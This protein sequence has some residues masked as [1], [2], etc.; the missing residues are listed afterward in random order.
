MNGIR[1]VDLT[2]VLAGPWATQQLADQGAEVIKIEPPTGDET[3][4]FGPLVQGHST[5]F[6]SANRNKR[7]ICL[8]LKTEAGRRVLADLV[9][10]ADV[11]IENFRPDVASR[12]GLDWP[13]LHRAHP[14]LVYVAIH[15]FG[16]TADPAWRHRPGYDLV[17][18]AMGGAAAATGFPGGPPV[19]N[20]TSVADLL[21]GL[22]AVQAVLLGLLERERSGQGQKIVVNMLQGQAAALAY[23]ATRYTVAGQ[24]ETQRGSAHAGLVPYDIFECRGGWLAL[25]CGNDAIGTRL[26]GALEL[27]D[28]EAWRTNVGRVAARAEVDRAVATALAPLDVHQADALLAKAGVPAGP[29]LSLDRT[30]AHPCVE[31][32]DLEHPVLGRVQSPGP[33][34]RTTTT[35]ARHRCPP[36]L[37]QDRADLIAELGYDDATLATLR[38][39]G[40]FPLET[41]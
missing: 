29:V 21:A 32:V 19:K 31:L 28:V 40:A 3:R 17:L 36:A 24:L 30:L 39:G 10:T 5:Y 2:R 25:A 11:V 1:I 37:D 12:L 6:L 16:D 15:A 20:A 7:A 35:R 27:A 9:A 4:G 34:V 38:A 8:D 13:A 41:P 18:Q 14:R 22:L 23:H 33:V 26:R